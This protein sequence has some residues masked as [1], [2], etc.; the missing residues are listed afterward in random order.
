[1][2]DKTTPPAGPVIWRDVL[3]P[4]RAHVRGQHTSFAH[5]PLSAYAVQPTRI[6]TGGPGR[7][8]LHQQA[9]SLLLHPS[10][11]LMVACRWD[12][13]GD[14]EGDASNEQAL[15]LSDDDGATWRMANDG[16]PII[17]LAHGTSF[18]RPSS[19]THSFPWCDTAGRTWL[20]YTVN[21]PFTWGAGQPERSTGG[22]EIRRVELRADDGDWRAAKASEVVWAF[23]RPITNGVDGTWTDVRL[24]CLNGV[25]RLR[26]GRCLMPVAGRSTVPDPAGAFWRLDRSWVLVSDDDGGTWTDLGFIGGS[27]ALCLCEP[28]LVETARDDHV[29]A[30]MRVQYDTGVELYRSDSF[31]AGATWTAPRATGLPNTGGSGVK[32]Y[33]VAL[34]GGAF[35]LLQ[36]NEHLVTDRTNVSL[37]LTDETGLALDR[38]PVVKVLASECADHWLGSAYGW[39]AEA[40]DGALHAVWVS[41]L[42]AENHLNHARIE[43]SWLT[44]T[45]AEPLAPNDDRGDDLPRPG[46]AAG[47]LAFPST[48]SRAHLP[49]VG[50]LAP[51]GFSLHATYRVDCAPRAAAFHLLELRTRNGRSLACR[52]TF[53]H[54]QTGTV[55]LDSNVGLHD[56]GQR[57]A[58]DGRIALDVDVTDDRRLRVAV[59][60]V[61]AAGQAYLKS[62]GPVSTAYLGGNVAHPEACEVVVERVQLAPL[63]GGATRDEGPA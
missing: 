62:V 58:A 42:G 9:A 14:A 2:H 49:R 61:A 6:A 43:P 54:D 32:P 23:C 25:V 50:L 45:V 51:G 28:T 57:P 12:E 41:Y 27:E 24:L 13:R 44:G 55:W 60:G 48:R 31:D 17:T 16:Q 37:F 10:G 47:G 39:L 15:Y 11:T 63:T 46:G 30:L 36:T 19:I 56:T 21:Q 59:N 29:V 5:E 38:W 3:D 18:E 52:V 34:R 8:L 35:A 40:P 26:S 1:M 53:G 33:A 22:G 7:R 4:Y 20:Y